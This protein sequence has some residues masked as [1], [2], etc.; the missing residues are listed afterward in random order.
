MYKEKLKQKGFTLIELVV[1]IALLGVV[2]ASTGL[3]F[4]ISI[5][6]HRTALANAEIMQKFRAISLQ[7]DSDFENLQKD[8]PLMM[9]FHH[10][11]NNTNERYDKIMFFATGDFQSTQRYYKHPQPIKEI[12]GEIPALYE[13]EDRFGVTQQRHKTLRGNTARIYYGLANIKNGTVKM[14]ESMAD[15]QRIL[16]RRRHILTLDP[17]IEKWPDKDEVDF[18]FSGYDSALVLA[19]SERYE[20]D[21]LSLREWK[22]IKGE[23]YGSNDKEILDIS[24]GVQSPYTQYSWIDLSHP[25]T[26]HNLMCEGVGSFAIQWAYW[27]NK[28]LQHERI[29]W[30]PMVDLDGKKNVSQQ[31]SHFYYNTGLSVYRHRFGV[32]FGV[33]GQPEGNNEWIESSKSQYKQTGGAF[34]NFYPK[35][36]KFTMRLYDSKGVIK[37]GRTF[38]KIIFLDR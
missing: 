32:L 24:F 29:R 5:E 33:E 28:D 37:G 17:D 36:L 1:A 22:N 26:L 25:Y 8:A 10:D 13:D 7:L 34:S 21:S 15:E 30:F 38:T 35:A 12:E 2:V 31:D 4:K 18:N 19:L 11:P 27:D 23:D 16:A 14:P 3:I 20:H 9:W 6:T